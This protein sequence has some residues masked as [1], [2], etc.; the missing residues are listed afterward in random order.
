[1]GQRSEPK[2]QKGSGGGSTNT[3]N[4]KASHTHTHTHI[5]IKLAA[6][7]GGEDVA[8]VGESYKKKILCTFQAGIAVCSLR[9]AKWEERKEKK[10]SE[11]K[12]YG[13][14]KKTE[15][16]SRRTLSRRTVERHERHTTQPRNLD[17]S[18]TNSG[19][20]LQNDVLVL[21]FR[22]LHTWVCM[23]LYGRHGARHAQPE[24][25]E[26]LWEE[27]D[28][29]TTV[30][31]RAE[32]EIVRVHVPQRSGRYTEL[33]LRKGSRDGE[34]ADWETD[35][36]AIEVRISDQSPDDLEP[37]SDVELGRWVLSFPLALSRTRP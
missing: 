11:V 4:V 33:C 19:K 1:V 21:R 20:R 28:G 6:E 34:P 3:G 18:T 29:A 10:R 5:D 8:W 32:Y 36:G 2:I 31:A 16:T 22:R 35:P 7:R 37:A 23:D 27:L 24:F 9:S 26:A 25:L 13:V 15:N 17:R 14:K 12:G 30:E